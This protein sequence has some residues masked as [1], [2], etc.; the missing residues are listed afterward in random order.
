M[1]ALEWCRHKWKFIK[2]YPKK[3]VQKTFSMQV[4]KQVVTSI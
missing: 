3:K 2:E 4:V 1:P